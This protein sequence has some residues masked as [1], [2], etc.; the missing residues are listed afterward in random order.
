MPGGM[1]SRGDTS[2]QVG[3]YAA[4]GGCCRVTKQNKLDTAALWSAGGSYPNL[5][6]LRF[7]WLLVHCAR[8]SPGM[9][10]SAW[11]GPAYSSSLTFVPMDFLRNTA[12]TEE[13]AR[14][15]AISE[16]VREVFLRELWCLWCL[17]GGRNWYYLCETVERVA[18]CEI[19]EIVSIH[20]VFLHF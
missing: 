3:C 17:F 4:T 6:I 1:G 14:G 12:F 5:L 20:G 10:G 11:S 18:G 16:W 7:Y 19:I 15:R 2:P 8:V 13:R 9:G